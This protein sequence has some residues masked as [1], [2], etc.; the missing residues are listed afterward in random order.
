MRY[1]IHDTVFDQTLAFGKFYSPEE[2]LDYAKKNWPSEISHLEVK[3]CPVDLVQ[4]EELGS[5]TGH[6]SHTHAL[7][8]LL[9]RLALAIEAQTKALDRMAESNQGLIRAMAEDAG[10]SDGDELRGYLNAR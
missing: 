10:E 6:P 7:E 2:A 4:S 1:S 8:V 9:T 3:P 5:N